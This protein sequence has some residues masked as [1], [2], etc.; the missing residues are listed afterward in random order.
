MIPQGVDVLEFGSFD[1]H[2]LA[3]LK[4]RRGL[5]IDPNPESVAISRERFPGLEFSSEDVETIPS[6]QK[7]DYILVNNVI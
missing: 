5:G 7:F 4:P 1:G 2:Q 3:A 6:E